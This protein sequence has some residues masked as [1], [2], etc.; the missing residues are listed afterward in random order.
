MTGRVLTPCLRCGSPDPKHDQVA[1]TRVYDPTCQHGH[2]GPHFDCPGPVSPAKV[3][4]GGR[5]TLNPEPLR[6]GT[7]SLGI[8]GVTRV[9]RRTAWIATGNDPALFDEENPE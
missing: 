8:T 6:V 1:C 2:I 4:K 5:L 9:M 3:A 7:R